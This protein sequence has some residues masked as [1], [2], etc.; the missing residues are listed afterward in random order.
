MPRLNELIA[1]ADALLALAPE[2]LA[3]YVLQVARSNMPNGLCHVQT[4]TNMLG[5]YG[6]EQQRHIAEMEVAVV[7]AWAWLEN[8]L[9]LVRAPGPNG[10]NG[11]RVLGRRARTVIDESQWKAVRAAAAFPKELLHPA[12]AE[13]AW[14]S[15]L[16]GEFDVAVLVAFRT[17]E[18][19][20]RAAGR[21]DDTDFGTALMR[22]AFNPDSGPL[23]DKSQPAAERE[24]LSNLF[25]GAIGSYKNPH[26]HRTVLIRD[27]AEAQDQVVL[28]SHLLRIVDARKPQ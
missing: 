21:F 25:A 10:Q 12:I 24:A 5:Q 22:R 8:Q 13:R 23:T 11:W 4:L 19:A 20:V 17:V 28:A 2:E 16:R 27:A 26:S 9:Y 1:N 7:E 14:V 6:P 18:E 15:L 3:F